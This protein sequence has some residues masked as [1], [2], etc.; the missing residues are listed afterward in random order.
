MTTK[1]VRSERDDNLSYDAKKAKE[2]FARKLADDAV[3][4]RSNSQM[5]PEADFIL[6]LL[7]EGE[8]KWARLSVF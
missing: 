3:G 6:T 5:K 8:F 1:R 4:R 2:I 7:R